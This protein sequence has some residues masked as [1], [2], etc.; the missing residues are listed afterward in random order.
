MGTGLVVGS[1][2]TRG[3]GGAVIPDGVPDHRVITTTEV[4]DAAP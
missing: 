1:S 3:P 4:V 2:V